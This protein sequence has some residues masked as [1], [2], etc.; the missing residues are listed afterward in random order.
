MSTA[1]EKAN[2]FN[3]F[4]AACF[5][6]SF[7]PLT[8]EYTRDLPPPACPAEMLCIEVDVFNALDTTKAC[9]PDGI[10]GK[11]LKVTASS[12]TPVLTKLFNLSI[13]TGTVPTAWKTSTVVPVPKCG[14]NTSDPSN[15]QSISLLSICDKMLERHISLLL[16][17]FLASCPLSSNQWGFTSKKSTVTELLSVLHDWHHYL[18]KGIELCAVFFDLQKAFDTVPHYPLL[19]KLEELG[20]NRYLLRW[21]CNYLL[22]RKQQVVVDGAISD[23]LPVISG[24][25]Q[26]SVLGPLLFLIYIDGVE[27]VT[28]SDGTIV[29]YADDMVLYQL[30]YSYED[31]WLLQQDINVIAMWIA[32]NHLQFNTSKCKYMTISWKRAKELPPTINLNGI[33]LDGVTE[34]KYLGILITADLSW[35]AHINMICT[36]ARRLV[37]MLYRHVISCRII[38]KKINK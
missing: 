20:V 12:I 31:Y 28:L 10:T 21:I 30:T 27:S 35:T 37:G 22:E 36:K 3:A 9:G 1:S 24:V 14:A 11:M 25:P 18:E 16:I 8:L 7:P 23:E 4:F 32:N 26:G 29:L 5:N 19:G 38:I 2:A 15:Y 34:F 33:P 6:Q 17:S 13:A